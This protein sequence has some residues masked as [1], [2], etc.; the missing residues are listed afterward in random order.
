MK[1]GLAWV[2]LNPKLSHLLRLDHVAR[3]EE[4][5][6][7]LNEQFFDL[8]DSCT[9]CEGLANVFRRRYALTLYGIGVACGPVGHCEVGVELYGSLEKQQSCRL[10]A[11]H[12]TIPEAQ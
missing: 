10:V 3:Q 4:M 6:V 7:A 5:V 9:K 8:S 2:R 12:P 11:I 1:N